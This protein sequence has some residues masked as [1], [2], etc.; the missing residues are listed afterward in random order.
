[1]T[2]YAEDTT[3]YMTASEFVHKFIDAHAGETHQ[4]YDYALSYMKLIDE[5]ARPFHTFSAYMFAQRDDSYKS[6]LKENVKVFFME[7]IKHKAVLALIDHIHDVGI[8]CIEARLA[9]KD[10]ADLAEYYQSY[11]IDN[12][13]LESVEN[14]QDL[15]II[16]EAKSRELDNLPFIPDKK[17]GTDK[18]SSKPGRMSMYRTYDYPDSYMD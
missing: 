17:S 12:L 10:A 4:Q 13:N 9:D 14:S 18:K 11:T 3:E 8:R 15:V 16:S 1:M 6:Y 7:Y 2:K 5:T